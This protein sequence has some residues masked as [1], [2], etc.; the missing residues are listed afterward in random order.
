[1]QKAIPELKFSTSKGIFTTEIDPSIKSLCINIQELSKKKPEYKKIHTAIETLCDPNNHKIQPPLT[2]KHIHWTGDTIIFLE[3]NGFRNK[4]FF[5]R[6]SKE[7]FLCYLE[8]NHI[9]CCEP[10]ETKMNNEDKKS[11]INRYKEFVQGFEQNY[12]I[13]EETSSITLEDLY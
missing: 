1:M 4:D 11:L 9:T 12:T 2:P 8:N 5:P 6:I 13:C 10:P 3:K 7:C